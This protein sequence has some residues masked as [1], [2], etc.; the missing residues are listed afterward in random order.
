MAEMRGV[1]LCESS[2]CVVRG[3]VCVCVRFGVGGV[4]RCGVCL[5]VCCGSGVILCANDMCGV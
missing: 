1:M 4:R 3:V 2:W 5:C